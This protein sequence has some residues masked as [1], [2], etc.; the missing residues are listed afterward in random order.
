MII[1]HQLMLKT[2]LKYTVIRVRNKISYHAFL[3]NMTILELYVSKIYES[4]KDLVS[5]KALK[6]K[7]TSPHSIQVLRSI[8]IGNT[9]QVLQ[10]IINNNA[11]LTGE[12]KYVSELEHNHNFEEKD[13]E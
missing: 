8:M 1:S 9:R 3:K 11:F 6:Q 5:Q 4:Y 10:T 12:N 2:M 13:K 7:Q